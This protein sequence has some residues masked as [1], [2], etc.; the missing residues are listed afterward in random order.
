[1]N[2][3]VFEPE[4]DGR[5][6]R[7]PNY[8]LNRYRYANGWTGYLRT[9]IGKY[10]S[11]EA[12]KFAQGYVKPVKH[13]G[14]MRSVGLGKQY[15]KRP[16]GKL[17]PTPA[18]RPNTG[19]GPSG[20]TRADRET[21]S[22]LANLNQQTT[23]MPYGVRRRRVKIYK[24]KKYVK[25]KGKVSKKYG[26][27][28]KA[29]RTKKYRRYKKKR[30]YHGVQASFEDNY[31]F[32]LKSNS[33][34]QNYVDCY[35]VPLNSVTV[36]SN[37]TASTHGQMGTPSVQADFK[38]GENN[39]SGAVQSGIFEA[40]KILGYAGATATQ[41]IY[42]VNNTETLCY[43]KIV[44]SFYMT[45]GESCDVRVMVQ[46]FKCA[47]D[48][49]NS[50]YGRENQMQTSQ[51]CFQSNITY[52]DQTFEPFYSATKVPGFKKYWKCV[53]TKYYHLKPSEN[54]TFVFKHK[55]VIDQSKYWAM[56][57]A[58]SGFFNFIKGKT[59][60]I[61]IS[62]RGGLGMDNTA[63]H[64]GGAFA[65]AAL[66]IVRHRFVKGHRANETASTQKQ[67][68]VNHVLTPTGFLTSG[69]A[70]L[71]APF[72]LVSGSAT[73]VTPADQGVNS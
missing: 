12:K 62:I 3:E 52:A 59:Y 63:T 49:D 22:T 9:V 38:L 18:K 65:P 44:E 57:N 16:G 47:M 24:K 43:D 26:K 19:A 28:R 69:D 34:Q 66:G 55:A 64:V 45:N 10:A 6:I 30:L 58:L 31:Q 8:H 27:R 32:K 7:R 13:M 50:M 71:C 35:S 2:Y 40:P 46:V 48:T 1:M 42:I 11:S 5:L 21:I 54:A 29:Y 68:V 14:P 25:R 70:V 51:Q 36:N 41:S 60:C 23:S 15:G 56:N 53:R 33:N 67:Y 39:V 20:L 61:R 72:T 73:A 4:E 17:P 37:A